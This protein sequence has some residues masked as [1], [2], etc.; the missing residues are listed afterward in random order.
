M[1]AI[2][3]FKLAL[4]RV[5]PPEHSKTYNMY[6]DSDL[7]NAEA[8]RREGVT[9]PAF[10][11][12]KKRALRSAIAGAFL[13]AAEMDTD[14]SFEALMSPQF[15]SVDPCRPDIVVK[16]DW[17]TNKN[18]GLD[19]KYHLSNLWRRSSRRLAE[20]AGHSTWTHQQAYTAHLCLDT[21]MMC[22]RV[23]RESFIPLWL[24]SYRDLL[25]CGLLENKMVHRCLTAVL[26][27]CD[28]P[29]PYEA[30]RR[31]PDANVLEV[32]GSI[33]YAVLGF[34][35]PATHQF[36]YGKIGTITKA[37]SNL[38]P[39]KTALR[40]EHVRGCAQNSFYHRAG[41]AWMVLTWAKGIAETPGIEVM[42]R[43]VAMLLTVL[44]QSRKSLSIDV[45]TATLAGNVIDI[46]NRKKTK[47]GASSYPVR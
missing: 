10:F 33:A 45:E 42:Q 20:L 35:D 43:D 27:F 30:F 4:D 17:L 46:L 24:E 1:E 15:R 8:A 11:M 7:D 22:S 38:A 26:A 5:C 9:P 31:E 16:F 44:E 12:R 14:E 40:F 28:Q 47:A 18:G 39:R 19:W 25:R 34:S 3:L 41:L 36:T 23:G 2:D 32:E 13:I 6:W 37:T 21:I 29:A